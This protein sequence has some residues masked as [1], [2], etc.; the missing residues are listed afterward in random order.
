MQERTKDIIGICAMGC[1]VIVLL[2]LNFGIIWAD[3]VWV[4]VRFHYPSTQDQIDVEVRA[5]NTIVGTWQKLNTATVDTVYQIGDDTLWEFTA[6][7]YTSPDSTAT[8]TIQYNRRSSNGP[9]SWHTPMFWSEPTDSVRVRFMKDSVT[10]NSFKITAKQSFDSAFTVYRD[11]A[12]SVIADLY[13]QSNSN[14]AA[15][16][17]NLIWRRVDTGRIIESPSANM[18]RL[19]GYVK[20]PNGVAARGALVTVTRGGEYNAISSTSTRYA[21]TADVFAVR[22]DSLGKFQLDVI[23][24]DQFADT[25]NAYYNV[26]CK[27]R[28]VELFNIKHLWAPSDS[29]INVLD[30]LAAR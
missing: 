28:S 21:V 2:L 8:W 30:T 11:T 24:S 12:Y 26:A 22:T 25:A 16:L 23:G 17:W 18:A 1:I 5:N 20:Q 4:P 19:Y 7:S 15:W 14:P 10:A 27:W 6:Y 3:S 29:T 13:Y 9:I